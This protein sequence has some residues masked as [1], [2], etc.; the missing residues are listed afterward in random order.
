[1]HEIIRTWHVIACRRF[2]FGFPIEVGGEESSNFWKMIFL[3]IFS[4]SGPFPYVLWQIRIIL[5]FADFVS[6]WLWFWPASR[7][8]SSL[9]KML[10]FYIFVPSMIV[11][12]RICL[13]V[14]ASVILFFYTFWKSFKSGK[15]VDIDYLNRI[16]NPDYHTETNV[17][18]LLN[19]NWYLLKILSSKYAEIC[20]YK[21]LH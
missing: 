20:W 18:P 21:Y 10:L 5:N 15:T 1:M 14:F 11:W 9:L 3:S 19:P 2:L 17:P 16:L 12:C 6:F 4:Y 7:S 13:F 8:F